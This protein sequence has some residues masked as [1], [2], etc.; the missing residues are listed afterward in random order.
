MRCYEQPKLGRMGF[1]ISRGD[2]RLDPQG[3]PLSHRAR[4]RS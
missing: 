4:A 2:E 1:L 3:Y